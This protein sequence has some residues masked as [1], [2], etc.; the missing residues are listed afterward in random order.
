MNRPSN[1]GV[2]WAADRNLTGPPVCVC[3]APVPGPMKDAHFFVHRNA[4]GVLI[5]ELEGK[6]REGPVSLQ[7]L[8]SE[9]RASMAELQRTESLQSFFD[10]AVSRIRRF[11][12]YDRVLAYKF[13]R[14]RQRLRAGGGSGGR[15]GELCRPPLSGQ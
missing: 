8:Y 10:L 12:G 2:R 3:T 14:G 9:V 11:T 7:D 6:G 13:L 15:S 4:N 5:V 1:S